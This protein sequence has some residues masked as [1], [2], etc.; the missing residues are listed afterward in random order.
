VTVTFRGQAIAAPVG[1]R[2][3]SALLAA[4]ASAAEGAA[5]APDMSPYNGRAR[6]FN[7]RGLGTCGTCA[8]AV[9]HGRVSPATP[10]AREAMRLRLPPHTD[11]NTA[12]K[13]LRL[14]CQIALDGDVELRK[15]DGMWG[16]GDKEQPF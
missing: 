15:Y 14:A 4:S 9:V 2:V 3:R 10:S 7:C 6:T 1:S 5:A 11:A 8:V 13:G 16:H 12:N